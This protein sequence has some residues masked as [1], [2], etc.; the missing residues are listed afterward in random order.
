L[1]LR[2]DFDESSSGTTAALDSGTAPPAPGTF[3][4]GATRTG[5]TPAGASLGALDAV[6][7]GYVSGGDADK[8][9]GLSNL[10]LTAWINLQGAPANGNRITAKQLPSGL[11]DGFSFAFSTPNSDPISASNFAI[12]LALGG[13]TF[14][15]NRSAVD[16]DADN[17]WIF[18]AATYNGSTVQFYSGDETTAPVALGSN[19]LSGTNPASL[20]ANSNEFRVAATG[21]VSAPVWIDDVRVYD[22]ALDATALDAVRQS[23]IPE[24]STLGLFAIGGIALVG[25]R[26]RV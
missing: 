22:T 19:L 17:K 12:N 18:V 13:S 4:L 14:G 3:N 24:P 8:L 20:T 23:N 6:V 10:T 11:F 5:N 26:R 9:D 2:Y 7:D 21:T 1:L 16:L 25:F 15:F